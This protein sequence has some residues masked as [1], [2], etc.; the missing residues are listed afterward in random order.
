[1]LS[2][3]D[4]NT[5]LRK[6]RAVAQHAQVSEGWGGQ[7]NITSGETRLGHCRE[8]PVNHLNFTLKQVESHRDFS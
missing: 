3:W 8:G 7:W 1:M 5:N 2:N 6:K 4:L